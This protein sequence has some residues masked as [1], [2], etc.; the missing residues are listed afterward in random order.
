MLLRVIHWLAVRDVTTVLH[1][2][3]PI[4]YSSNGHP[5][6]SRTLKSHSQVV[7]QS[8]NTQV[9]SQSINNTSMH[10]PFCSF[11]YTPLRVTDKVEPNGH[12]IN[13]RGSYIMCNLTLTQAKLV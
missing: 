11:L 6:P 5:I 8:T 13:T 7:S 4:G 2:H 1:I 12:V 3:C 10:L 9:V